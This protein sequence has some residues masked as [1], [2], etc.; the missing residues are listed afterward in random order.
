MLGRQVDLVSPRRRSMLIFLLLGLVS[1]LA[2]AVYE[3]GRSISG[4]YLA[5][6]KAPAVGAALIGVGEFLGLAFRLFSGYLATIYQSS[7]V[8]WA[9]TMLGYAATALSI[10]LIAFAPT[11][12]GVVALYMAERLGKGLRTPTRDVILAEV[13]EELG[14]GKGFGI[15][16]LLDQLGAFAG[17]VL[18]SVLLALFGYKVAYLALIAPGM[19]SVL[20]VA[21]AWR[22]HPTLRS[23]RSV[24]S[25]EKTKLELR[26]YSRQFWIYTAASSALALGLMHWS[27]ASYYLKVRGAA[28]DVEIGLAYAVAML[29]DALVAVPL[30]VLFDKV[31]LKLMPAIPALLPVFAAMVAYAP[32]WAV[33]LLAIP[34][35][36]VMCSEESVMRA[37][38]AVLVEPSKR[39]LAYGV[40]GLVFGLAWA[41]GGY[42]YTALLGEPLHMVLYAAAMSAA[43]TYLY[44][45]L[46]R[47]ARA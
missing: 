33:Y 20:L 38:I 37:S 9:S 8:L 23:L 26:G 15:H 40:F 2:D 36:I 4:A 13:A 45:A 7:A 46:A 14:V 27:I 10:P 6:I 5:E 12:H 34:W 39:P 18:V 22:L 29:V 1:L 47:L 41:L 30:G 43:A 25:A 17:P 42:V 24:V 31:R 32:R 28:S 44:S 16:E 3:G 11:W 19:A 35:G 21:L